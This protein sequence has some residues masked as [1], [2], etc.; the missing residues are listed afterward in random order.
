MEE[1]RS[2]IKFNTEELIEEQKKILEE[3]QK[4]KDEEKQ[5]LILYN[6]SDDEEGDMQGFEFIEGKESVI[7]YIRGLVDQYIGLSFDD[8]Y[9]IVDSVTINE[10]L[11][12]R[13]FIL[14]VNKTLENSINIEDE[15]EEEA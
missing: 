7:A 10:R 1:L 6:I 14:F 12:L 5:Y 2:A 9:I 13:E 15:S 3:E 4:R 8:S 11:T